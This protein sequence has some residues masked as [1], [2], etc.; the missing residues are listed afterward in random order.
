MMR[1][2]LTVVEQ[3]K[4]EEKQCLQ[5]L[6]GSCYLRIRCIFAP[7]AVWTATANAGAASVGAL[8]HV[9]L[10]VA[11]HVGAALVCQAVVQ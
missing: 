3:H 11:R 1:Q 10:C 6:P 5:K 7:Q 8:H 4:K 2:P 9:V